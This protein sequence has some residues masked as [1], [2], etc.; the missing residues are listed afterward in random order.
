M[1]RP[2]TYAVTAMVLSFI[3]PDPGIEW[4]TQRADDLLATIRS[5]APAAQ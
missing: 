4:T 5:Y 1:W 3:E 2:A